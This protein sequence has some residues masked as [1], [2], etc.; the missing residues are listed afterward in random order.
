MGASV[1]FGI[2]GNQAKSIEMY[3]V[4]ASGPIRSVFALWAAKT[5]CILPV[6]PLF[7]MKA[8][9]AALFA[10]QSVETVKFGPMNCRFYSS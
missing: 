3:K 2:D 10:G 7:L 4:H 6:E 1:T 9:S 5:T 8:K